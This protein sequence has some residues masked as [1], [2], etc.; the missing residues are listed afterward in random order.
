[1]NVAALHDAA[2]N[3]LDEDMVLLTPE[4]LAYTM[5][6]HLKTVHELLESGIL[7][8]ITIPVKAGNIMLLERRVPAQALLDWIGEN[9]CTTVAASQSGSR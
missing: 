5:Q 2:G 1:M 7:P 8:S 3:A 6:L 4:K 9:T